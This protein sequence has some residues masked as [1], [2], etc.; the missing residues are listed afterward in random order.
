V[1][2][3]TRDNGPVTETRYQYPEFRDFS[4]N[5]PTGFLPSDQTHKARLWATFTVPTSFGNFTF[6][7]LQRLDSGIAYSAV[8]TV[9]YVSD[10]TLEYQP[11][12][13]YDRYSNSPQAVNY[14]FSDRGALRWDDIH[15]TDL[16]VNYRVSI[17]RAELFVQPEIVNVFNNNGVFQGTTTVLT[18]DN[19]DT[20]QPFN[21]FTETP[22][23][24]VHYRYANEDDGNAFGTARDAN[25][26]QLSRTY[27]ISFGVRF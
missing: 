17:G 10:P 4:R 7:G 21:P 24:G 11:E 5:A 26:Y 6:S 25:D 27:R 16:S 22:V 13:T 19:D 8:G 12:A 14:F 2:A 3:E 9:N 18:F 20:L 15:A 23:E 1:L